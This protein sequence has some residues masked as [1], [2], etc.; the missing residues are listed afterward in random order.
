MYGRTGAQTQFLADAQPEISAM[1]IYDLMELTGMVGQVSL[2]E[3]LL[4]PENRCS[5]SIVRGSDRDS[6]TKKLGEIVHLRDL[7]DSQAWETQLARLR[8]GGSL[9]LGV[10]AVG[11]TEADYR[12]VTY[13]LTLAVA[14]NANGAAQPRH[15][16]H[17]MFRARAPTAPSADARCGRG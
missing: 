15:D 16:V 14:K 10:S 13:E 6:A 1:K 11:M 9:P 7:V 17:S 3:C 12:R 5:C 2:R 8:C 4:D